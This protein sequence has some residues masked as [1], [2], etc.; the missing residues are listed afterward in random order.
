MVFL[1]NCGD[2]GVRERRVRARIWPKRVSV[3][4]EKGDLR[5]TVLGLRHSKNCSLRPEK[6]M[7]GR[8]GVKPE[9][10]EGER[11]GLSHL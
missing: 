2:G 11:N 5:I 3:G 7:L 10:S 9:K 4:A 6:A 1:R 8:G